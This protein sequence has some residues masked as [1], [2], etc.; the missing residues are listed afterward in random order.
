MRRLGR[1]D[2]NV[3]DKIR[4]SEKERMWKIRCERE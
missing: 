4:L 1:D 2:G 3:D